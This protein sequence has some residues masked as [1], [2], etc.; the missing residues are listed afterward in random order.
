MSYPKEFFIRYSVP[1]RDGYPE[2]ANTTS[3]YAVDEAKA[4]SK[5]AEYFPG[6]TII[7]ILEH[8]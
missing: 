8:Y 2:Y 1:A 5:F 7:T 3:V 4:R 6:C